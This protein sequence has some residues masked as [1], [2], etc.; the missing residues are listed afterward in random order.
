MVIDREI[1]Y[2]E[3]AGKFPT[4]K[5]K[6]FPLEAEAIELSKDNVKKTPGVRLRKGGKEKTVKET[7]SEEPQ[8]VAPKTNIQPDEE[9]EKPVPPPVKRDPRDPLKWFGV[10]VP[11]MLKD[12]QLRFSNGSS[13]HRY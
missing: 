10:F 5:P 2:E 9:E 12:A 3:D 6:H 1:S 8:S 7:S 4:F 11:P 13:I